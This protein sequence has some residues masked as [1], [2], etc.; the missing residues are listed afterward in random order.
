MSHFEMMKTTDDSVDLYFQGWEIEE[1]AKGVVCL[2]HGLGE[3]SGRYAHVGERL[4][5]ARYHMMAFDLPGHGKTSG[6]RGDLP[7]Y[8]VLNKY[9]TLMLSEASRRYPTLP[10]ILFGHSM[11]GLVVLYYCLKIKPSLAGVVATGTGL[12]T[13]LEEQKGKILLVKLL[14]PLFPGLVIA[15]GLDTSALSRDAQVVDDYQKDLLVHDRATLG[16]GFYSLKAIQYIYGNARAWDLPLLLMHGTDD[17]LAYPKGSEDFA[18]L[19]SPKLCTLK[20]WQGYY[21]EL[22]NEPGKEE[23]FKYLITQLDQFIDK[24]A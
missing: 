20:L 17:R 10:Q 13:A 1:P 23:V 11:G 5:Q 16:L 6:K 9:V 24:V 15:S 22:H 8:D 2:V 7:T 14:G 3:H 18:E 4:N 21:H 19:V 12:K